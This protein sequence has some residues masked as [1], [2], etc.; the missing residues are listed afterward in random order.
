V[1]VYVFLI[2]F[3]KSPLKM[4]LSDEKK[5]TKLK[6]NY[7]KE[8]LQVGRINYRHQRQLPPTNS[9]SVHS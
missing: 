8:E 9:S 7:T 2:G 1:G 6:K 5:K 4:H 3:S